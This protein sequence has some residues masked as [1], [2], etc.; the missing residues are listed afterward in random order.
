MISIKS[1]KAEAL[2]FRNAI[3]ACDKEA[4]TVVFDIFPLGN[5]HQISM[6]LAFHY[7]KLCA[8][9][10]IVVF[11]GESEN[12]VSHVWLEIEGYAIDLTGDQ[13]NSIDDDILNPLVIKYRPY[14]SV[15]VERISESYLYQV[16]WCNEK[17]TLKDYFSG[18]DKSFV[19]KM[20]HS[21]QLILKDLEIIRRDIN[22]INLI[23]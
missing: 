13:Y 19:S 2:I 14:P 3:N 15:H 22:N 9:V 18:I 5:C 4:S 17:F 21:Y 1:L 6:F 7:R 12:S 23:V 11:Y 10:D 16:F 20:E 8:E